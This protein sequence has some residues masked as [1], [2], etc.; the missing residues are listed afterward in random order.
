MKKTIIKFLLIILGALTVCVLGLLAY[1]YYSYQDIIYNS[2]FDEKIAEVQSRENYTLYENLSKDYVNGIIATED[3][4]FYDHQGIDYIGIARA[5]F[6][7][8]KNKEFDEGGS[9]L[10]QQVA[11]NIFLIEETNQVKRK[12]TE[13]FLANELEDRYSK[14]KIIELYANSIFFGNGNYCVNDACND[15]LK[16]EIADVSLEEAAMLAGIPNA[17]SVYNPRADKELCKS[18]TQKVLWAMKDVRIYNSGRI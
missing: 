11:K 2:A 15:Y 12:M 10:T 16:K 4:R 5:I 17:P 7:N 13:V 1:G 9:S 3:R 18:R 14:E 6:V 8:V